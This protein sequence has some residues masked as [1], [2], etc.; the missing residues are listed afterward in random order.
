MPQQ[1]GSGHYF[2]IA[3]NLSVMAFGGF[4]PDTEPPRANA[5]DGESFFGVIL[6]E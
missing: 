5:K 6:R 4:A 1:V 2:R 3:D